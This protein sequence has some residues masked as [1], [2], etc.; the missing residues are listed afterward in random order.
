MSGFTKPTQLPT[1]VKQEIKEEVFDDF[2]QEY[3]STTQKV[4]EKTGVEYE[5]KTEMNSSA[6]M[7]LKEE[8]YSPME[9][10]VEEEFD[11]RENND[12]DSSPTSKWLVYCNVIYIY[13]YNTC[14]L[15]NG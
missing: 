6:I 8:K 4:E 10:K 7:T 15:E 12:F 3:L 2:L 14:I 13:I 9:I 5:W 11:L 1:S